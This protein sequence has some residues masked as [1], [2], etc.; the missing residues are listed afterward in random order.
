MS[1]DTFVVVVVSTGSRLLLQPTLFPLS[2]FPL[3]HS[4]VASLFTPPAFTP[5]S[6]LSLS[7]RLPPARP[8]SSSL[9]LLSL[10]NGLRPSFFHGVHHRRAAIGPTLFTPFLFSPFATSMTSLLF[11]AS[12]FLRFALITLTVLVNECN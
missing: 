11:Y 1:C 7:S 9:S 4:P 10:S 12:I 2:A 5:F 8:S 6:N 3:S